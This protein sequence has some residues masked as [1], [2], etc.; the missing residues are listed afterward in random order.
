MVVLIVVCVL[1]GLGIITG[2]IIIPYCIKKHYLRINYL[3]LL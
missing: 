1:I 2:Y 3:N